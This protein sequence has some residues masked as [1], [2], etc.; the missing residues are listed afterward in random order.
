MLMLYLADAEA[1]RL[2]TRRRAAKKASTLATDRGR[3]HRHI[4]PLLGRH[5][6]ASLT[7]E[8]IE[9]FMHDVAAGKTAGKTKTGPHGLAHVHGGKGTASRTVGLLGAIFTYAVRHRMRLD[10]PVHGVLRPADGRRE[11]RLTDDVQSIRR[12]VAEIGR[13]PHLAR[14]DYRRAIQY[15]VRENMA[16]SVVSAVVSRSW[17]PFQKAPSK[18]TCAG[19]NP[20]CPASQCGLCSCGFR[21]C[22]NCRRF[23]RESRLSARAT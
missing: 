16:L 21:L 6:V 15:F 19:S 9:A 13:S 7:R 8:D 2:I 4:K 17:L 18:R 23:R 1:G 14:R 3:I 11:R 20:P 12:R 5:A 10:N 22:E